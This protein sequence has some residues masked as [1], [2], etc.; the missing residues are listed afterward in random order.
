VNLGGEPERDDSGLPP[1]D[2]VV[3]DDARELERDV[4]AYRRELRALRRRQRRMRWHRPSTRDGV[5]LPLLAS[6][7]VLALIAGTLLTVF[8]AGPSGELQG[9]GQP[10]RPTA[11][12]RPAPARPPD[13]PLATT[14]KY[15]L[16]DKAVITVDGKPVPYPA[17]T[18]AVIALVPADCGCGGVLERLVSQ[19]GAAHV[20]VYLVGG[21]KL[22]SVKQLTAQASKAWPHSAVAIAQDARGVLAS[23]YLS[24]ARPP[25]GAGPTALLVAADGSVQVTPPLADSF[26]LGHQLHDISAPTG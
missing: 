23:R 1:V 16:P 12:A 13:S 17:L 18:S 15:V 19:A 21:A 6:C 24:P 14:S 25:A 26:R 2:I 22:A 8:T 10:A 11:T 20:M 4:Q 7:L 3:P 5:I 9:S